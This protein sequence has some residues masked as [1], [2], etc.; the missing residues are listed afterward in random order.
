MTEPTGTT[1]DEQP[2]E[3]ISAPPATEQALSPAEEPAKKPSRARWIIIAVLVLAVIGAAAGGYAWYRQSQAQGAAQ[4]KIDEAITLVEDADVVVL[5]VDEIVR[6]EITPEVGAQA[7]E[8]RERVPE[9]IAD[10]GR[11]TALIDEA[12]PDLPEDDVEHARAVKASAEARAEMLG[13]VEP[14]LEANIKAAAALQPALDAWAAVLEAETLAD[15]AIAEYNKLT[16][17][18][19]TRSQTLTADALAKYQEA[20]ELFSTAAT[21]FP[22]ADFSAYTDYV[23]GKIELLGISKQANDAFLAGNKAQA[24][25]LSNQYNVKDKELVALAAELPETPAEVVASAYEALAGEATT[26]YFEARQ[27]ATDADAALKDLEQ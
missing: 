22:E 21:G 4:S 3:P 11:A 13:P 27:R 24:N 10:L 1:A 6:A 20:K 2:A 23:A 9:A 25:T 16:N 7:E 5:D 19:V 15:R 18:D 14:I 8:V 26:R 12:V 17:E